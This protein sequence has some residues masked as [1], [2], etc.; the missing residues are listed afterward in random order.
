MTTLAS[1]PTPD[2][3]GV[4]HVVSETQELAEEVAHGLAPVGTTV[5]YRE[6]E[7][8]VVPVRKP[9]RVGVALGST[10]SLEGAHRGAQGFEGVA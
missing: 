2:W 8:V 3:P 7:E 6:V 10:G 5:A 4:A 1:W 9:R